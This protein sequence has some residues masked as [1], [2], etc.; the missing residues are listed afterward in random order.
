MLSQRV[1]NRD[2]RFK[3]TTARSVTGSE[4]YVRVMNPDKT[5][6]PIILCDGYSC[7]GFVWAYHAPVW[8]DDRPVVL[9]HYPGHGKSSQPVNALDISIETL[10]IDLQ[11]VADRLGYAA[12]IPV[13]FSM[14]VQVC[15]EAWRRSKDSIPGYHPL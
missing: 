5:G 7:D 12:Y 6:I 3:T 8:A 10:A 13:G 1:Q 14:G 4:L 2:I 9:W 15:V 11:C